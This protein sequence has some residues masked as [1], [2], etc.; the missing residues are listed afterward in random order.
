MKVESFYQEALRVLQA[1]PWCSES[2]GVVAVHITN[3]EGKLE[4]S[5][6]LMSDTPIQ[7]EIDCYYW[8]GATLH[9]NTRGVV[10]WV[11]QALD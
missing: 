7:F 10:K 11:F 4:A 2:F 6:D 9:L 8:I 3:N 5:I 1:G